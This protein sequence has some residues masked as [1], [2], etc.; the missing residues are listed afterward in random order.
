MVSCE[1]HDAVPRPGAMIDDRWSHTHNNTAHADTT[2]THT[3]HT[4][5][6]TTHTQTHR[7]RHTHTHTYRHRWL[8]RSLAMVALVGLVLAGPHR[9]ME[10][11]LLALLT[12]LA[13][14]L[15]AQHFGC[16]VWLLRLR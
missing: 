12:L 1:G 14:L 10:V 11:Q 6:H 13:L 8:F 5:T 15:L 2:H 16:Y 7:H 3:T 9:R 4:H